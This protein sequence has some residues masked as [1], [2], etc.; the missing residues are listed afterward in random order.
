MFKKIIQRLINLI[1]STSFAIIILVLIILAS[2]GGS[3]I[4]QNLMMF[5]YIQRY[6]RAFGLLFNLQLIGIYQSWWF[7]G[8][9]ALFG[10]SLLVCTLRKLKHWRQKY[11]FL[12]THAALLIILLALL[13]ELILGK[14]RIPWVYSGFILLNIGVIITFYVKPKKETLIKK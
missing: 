4:P 12:I 5:E 2:A 13:S 9:L 6:G 3:L 1:G 10:L 8:L 14:T 11:G 7:I